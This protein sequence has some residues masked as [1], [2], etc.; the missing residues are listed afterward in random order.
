MDPRAQQVT[1]LWRSFIISKRAQ[2]LSKQPLVI[3]SLRPTAHGSKEL[4]KMPCK[5]VCSAVSSPVRR[6]YG[7]KFATRGRKKISNMFDIFGMFLIHWY[8]FEFFSAS[9][10][11]FLIKISPQTRGNGWKNYFAESFC[12]VF[13]PWRTQRAQVRMTSE[14]VASRSCY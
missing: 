1:M 9:R 13:H 6:N 11:E 14:N 12:S 4:R 2:I 3:E 7:E 10:G 5:A 8:V